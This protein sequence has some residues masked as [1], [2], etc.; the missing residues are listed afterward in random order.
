[1][2]PHAPKPGAGD[3]EPLEVCIAADRRYCFR[4]ISLPSFAQSVQ[5]RRALRGRSR[6]RE[7]RPA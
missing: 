5:R 7:G 2:P 6:V 3:T 4:C 1:M